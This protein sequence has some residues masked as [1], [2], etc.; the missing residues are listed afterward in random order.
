MELADK[1][2][3]AIKF[4]PLTGRDQQPEL[5]VYEL[6]WGPTKPV[7]PPTPEIIVWERMG[8]G[9]PTAVPPSPRAATCE[10]LLLVRIEPGR[11]RCPTCKKTRS[12]GGR[13]GPM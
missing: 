3:P 7:P 2:D 10:C 12:F 6:Y 13:R 5:P 8:S 4:G 9:L 1:G 11:Y